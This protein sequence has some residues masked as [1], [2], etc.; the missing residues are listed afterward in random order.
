MIYQ[1][2]YLTAKMLGAQKA[3]SRQDY[4]QNNAFLR[5]LYVSF[6]KLGDIMSKVIG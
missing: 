6:P 4:L 1:L 5:L 2:S 3:P